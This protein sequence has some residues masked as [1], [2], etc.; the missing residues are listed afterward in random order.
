MYVPGRD[1]PGSW[2]YGG[3]SEGYKMSFGKFISSAT[4]LAGPIMAMTPMGKLAGLAGGAMGALGGGGAAGGGGGEAG[5]GGGGG[6]MGAAGAP[7]GSGGPGGGSGP[8]TIN[9]P[10]V[11][12]N[13]Q[14]SGSDMAA[15]SGVFEEDIGGVPG[16]TDNTV[17]PGMTDNTVAPQEPEPEPE[18]EQESGGG[19]G[20]RALQAKGGKGVRALQ[21]NGGKGVRALQANGGK[22]GD[23][24]LARAARRS[25]A[26]AGRGGG[27]RRYTEEFSGSGVIPQLE[28]SDYPLL[29]FALVAILVTLSTS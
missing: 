16:M 26:S 12:I 6:M 23:G 4:K 25:A 11:R 19:I 10:P 18:P 9:N 5:G 15:S 22:G 8:I 14:I 24:A 3:R 29:G 20:G 1:P 13:V 7:G 27:R 17:A 28:E 2:I 21:A